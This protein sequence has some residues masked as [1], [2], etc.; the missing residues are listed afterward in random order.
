LLLKELS[1]EALNIEGNSF[2]AENGELIDFFVANLP[3]IK[4]YWSN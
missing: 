4:L 2:S 3:N 1:I